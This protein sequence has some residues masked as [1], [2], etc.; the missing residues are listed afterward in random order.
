MS[1]ELAQAMM[2]C[3][4][5]GPLMIAVAKLFAA[6]QGNEFYTFG[7][8][9][10]GTVEKGQTVRVLGEQ[11]SLDDDED[12]KFEIVSACYMSEAR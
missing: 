6:P 3:D 11:Y 2:E 5:D 1:S 10:S 9:M 4:P 7:R 8:I 12:M